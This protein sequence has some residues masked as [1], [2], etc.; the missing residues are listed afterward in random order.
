LFAAAE[1]DRETKGVRLGVASAPRVPTPEEMQS[2]FADVDFNYGNVRG[3]CRLAYGHD[4][5][6]V[7]LQTL[8]FGRQFVGLLP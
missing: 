2:V 1:I 4:P 6:V 8:G 3:L 7:A 5:I